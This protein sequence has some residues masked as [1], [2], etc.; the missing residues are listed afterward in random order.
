MRAVVGSAV[1]GYYTR[2]GSYAVFANSSQPSFRSATTPP[3]K[4]RC[5]KHEVWREY[6]S[7]WRVV[8]LSACKYENTSGV[9]T[10]KWVGTHSPGIHYRVRARFLGDGLNHASSG[11]LIYFKFK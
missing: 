8:G 7:G 2:S 9:V 6:S 5:I 10:W 4:Y 3:R 11:K 1:A